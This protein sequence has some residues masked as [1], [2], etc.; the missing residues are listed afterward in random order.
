M[1]PKE[2]EQEIKNLEYLSSTLTYEHQQSAKIDLD[3]K[4]KH[5]REVLNELKQ[6][7]L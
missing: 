3:M 7:Q 2:T 5:L 1:S 4:A 6:M